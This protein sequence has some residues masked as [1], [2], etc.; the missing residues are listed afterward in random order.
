MTQNAKYT[1][2][3]S[4]ICITGVSKLEAAENAAK[5]TLK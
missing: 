4:N 1:L 3:V 2:K 5:T